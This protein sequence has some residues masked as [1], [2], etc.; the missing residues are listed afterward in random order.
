MSSQREDAIYG[1]PVGQ[2]R[3]PEVGE[4]WMQKRA[5]KAKV[6]IHAVHS[7]LDWI[8]FTVKRIGDHELHG[9][10]FRKFLAEYEFRSLK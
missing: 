4:I 5:P 8:E 2:Y 3:Q 9:E 6:K 10:G 1:K 7:K